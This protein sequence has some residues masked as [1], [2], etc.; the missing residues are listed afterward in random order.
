MTICD[1]D[2]GA[3]IETGHNRLLGGRRQQI[4]GIQLG[5]GRTNP[6]VW[7]GQISSNDTTATLKIN[8]GFNGQTGLG[9]DRVF[10]RLSLLA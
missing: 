7:A 5:E 2:V 1:T 4:L 9:R 10:A 8:V 6:S 3:I